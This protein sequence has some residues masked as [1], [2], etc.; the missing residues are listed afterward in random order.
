[1][2]CVYVH[3]CT[4][5]YICTTWW[6]DTD[7]TV[8]YMAGY[9]KHHH[10]QSKHSYRNFPGQVIECHL[11]VIDKTY[12]F[13]RA[14]TPEMGWVVAFRKLQ[15]PLKEQEIRIIAGEVLPPGNEGLTMVEKS[16]LWHVMTPL[17]AEQTHY[18]Y[19]WDHI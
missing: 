4:Y 19:T 7:D 11:L 1:M 9:S 13:P 3:I 10:T 2:I 16:G 5:M 15:G 17:G 12:L 8:T 18:R 14:A 6:T